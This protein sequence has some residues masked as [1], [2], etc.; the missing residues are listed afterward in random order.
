MNAFEL[1]CFSGALVCAVTGGII[2]H[3]WGTGTALCAAAVGLMTPFALGKLIMAVDEARF[4]RTVQGRRR[5]IAE[6][7]CDKSHGQRR[8]GAWR[9]RPQIAQDGSTIVTVFH[10]DTI[11]PL[12]AFYRFTAD[13]MLPQEI[14]ADEAARHITVHTMR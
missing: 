14:D 3:R 9:I 7:E 8:G 11:P 10:G 1:G 13:S 12:R 4:A 6:A 5:F 2:G